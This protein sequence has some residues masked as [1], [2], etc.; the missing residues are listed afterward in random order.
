MNIIKIIF[1]KDDSWITDSYK[2]PK[3]YIGIIFVFIYYIGNMLSEKLAIRVTSLMHP[4]YILESQEFYKLLGTNPWEFTGIRLL[5]VIILFGI[6]YFAGI[7]FFHTY[8][9]MDKKKLFKWFVLGLVSL[10]ILQGISVWMTQINGSMTANQLLLNKQLINNNWATKV[11]VFM[12]L[13]AFGEELVMRGIIQRYVFS[14]LP[15]IGIFVSA[16]LFQSMHYTTRLTDALLYFASGL[17][18]A[19]VYHKTGKLELTMGLHAIN[20]FI[21]LILIG[22]TYKA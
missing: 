11:I 7:K 21:A 22:L 5:W 6:M 18:F 1:K 20:N 15:Y 14:K 4:E 17:V 10:S 3:F 8:K 12:L 2:T 19:V 9:G 13:P 16:F